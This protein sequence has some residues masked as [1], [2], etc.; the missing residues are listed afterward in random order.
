M[1][2][3]ANVNLKKGTKKLTTVYI[4]HDFI[5]LVLPAHSRIYGCEVR[6]RHYL[7]RKEGGGFDPEEFEKFPSRYISTFSKKVGPCNYI[8]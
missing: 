8:I 5:L 4:C 7:E 2:R 3:Y 6:R 1:D